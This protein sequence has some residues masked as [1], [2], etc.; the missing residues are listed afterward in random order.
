MEIDLFLETREGSPD[1]KTGI[2]E[3]IFHT[4]GKIPSSIERLKSR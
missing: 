2:T 4:V 3:Q 1:L